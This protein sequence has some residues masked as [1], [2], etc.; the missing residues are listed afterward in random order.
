MLSFNG[1]K[2]V[3][4]LPG[5]VR[6]R[7]D[8]IKD[9][10]GFAERLQGGLKDI[11]GIKK[12]ELKPSTSSVLVVYDKKRLKQPDAA[13]QLVEQMHKLFPDLGVQRLS[14]LLGL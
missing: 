10:A 2:V 12:L 3:S 4:Y 8:K 9:E 7:I 11:P 1:I 14:D 6:L 13:G 5:R